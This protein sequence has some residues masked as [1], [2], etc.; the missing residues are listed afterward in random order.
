MGSDNFEVEG[1]ALKCT[2][3]LNISC[4]QIAELIEMPFWLW[5]RVGSKNLVWGPDSPCEGTIFRG[6]NMPGYARRHYA[7]SCAKIDN[8]SRCLLHCGLKWAEGSM[9]YMGAHWHNVAN[10]TETSVC[11]SNAVLCQITV[12]SCYWLKL[13]NSIY[14]AHLFVLWTVTVTYMYC[15]K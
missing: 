11:R 6:K 8:R 7:M 1:H 2:T 13:L 15:M 4:V 5:A 10:T 9:C 12:T 14:Y 3:T